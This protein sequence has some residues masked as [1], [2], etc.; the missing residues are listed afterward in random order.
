MRVLERQKRR[1]VWAG[2]KPCSAV[3]ELSAAKVGVTS[4]TD[5]LKVELLSEELMVP[6]GRGVW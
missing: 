6:I 4:E 2:L 5:V 1:R 3:E